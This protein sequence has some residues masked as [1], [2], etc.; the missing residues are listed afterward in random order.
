[1]H[2]LLE[3]EGKLIPF[4]CGMQLWDVRDG[5]CRQTFSGHESDINA[6]GVSGADCAPIKCTAIF[7]VTNDP[8]CLF[9]SS[10]TVSRLLLD[11]MMLRVASSTFEQTKNWPCIRM[12]TLSVALLQWRSPNR[13]DYF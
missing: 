1:M 9:S 13:V 6:I 5:M 3:G 8:V 10:R 11:L 2:L 7:L 4:S 12:T